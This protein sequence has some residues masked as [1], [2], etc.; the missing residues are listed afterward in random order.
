MI[1]S[2][3][4]LKFT[5]SDFIQANDSSRLALIPSDSLITP[6]DSLVAPSGKAS[7]KN[8]IE[9]TINYTARD[10]MIFEI[11]D[12]R[13][14]LYGNTHI[15]YGSITL[16]SDQT[17][18]DWNERNIKSRYT[19]DTLG[20]KRGKPVFSQGGSVYE[21]DDILYNF[22]TKRA[23]IKGVITE[24]DGA[25]MH[26]EDVKKNE[27]N[28]L[29]IKGA[30]YTTCNLSDPHFFI[31]SEKIKVIPGNKVLSGP[32]N[33]KFREVPTPLWFPFGMFPQPRQKAS[34]IVF[35]SYGEETRRGF[36]LRGGGYYFGFSEYFDLKLTG[37]VYS[38]GGY[39]LDATTN[40]KV[41][42][43]FNGSMNF[44]Y[45]K[46]VT[47]TETV[48][49]VTNDFWVRWSHRPE[50]RGNSSFSAS[51]NG[52]TRG[53]NTNNN[54]AIYN[55]QQSISSEFQSSL[56]YSQKFQRIP[57]NMSS[58]FRQRQN[59]QS[60]IYNMSLPDFALNM[61][62]MYPFKNLAKSSNSPIAKISF[63]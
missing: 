51:V 10:S 42:Y 20:R 23:I 60:G 14:F 50:T 57:F 39:A 54:V 31:K 59:I 44:A 29:F 46:N 63:S 56:S 34:G 40:Y 25:I 32:F 61:N 35:P 13:L 18:I 38:K 17:T 43:K 55:P 26:G 30:K 5:G 45:N 37:D 27:E 11:E 9:T 15:D 4:E 16:E 21:T 3:P 62:R 2:N 41:R 8:D 1:G 19:L 7:K 33:L 58:T 49:S 47:E 52:G 24:Q 6:P 12:R 36:F 22:K 53:F 28:E 48:P